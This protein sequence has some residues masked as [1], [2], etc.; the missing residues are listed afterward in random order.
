MLPASPNPPLQSAT[1]R[2][3]EIYERVDALNA[4]Y[5]TSSAD[6]IIGGIV[7]DEFP[8]RVAVVSSFGAESA[9]LLH[10]IA[11]VDTS[12]A[13]IFLDTLR[14]FKETLAY[15]EALVEHL[16]LRNIY[17]TR[18]DPNGLAAD[19][20]HDDLALR[21]PDRCCHIRKTLPMVRALQKFE[22]LMTGR[23]RFQASTRVEL[24]MF[25]AQDRWIKVN[26]IA[27]W[28]KEDVE[29]YFALSLIHI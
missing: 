6:A 4:R 12:V 8:G 21:D 18:P 2:Q 9:V 19:D 28:G 17:A 27:R 10:L 14:H 13:V 23:K 3:L 16:G 26:P 24:P 25:E 7:R 20:P 29:S 15:H 1:L 5:G 22:C 11:S